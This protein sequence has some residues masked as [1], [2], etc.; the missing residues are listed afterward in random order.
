VGAKQYNCCIISAAEI[1]LRGWEGQMDK[2]LKKYFSEL[3]KKGNKARNEKLTP[4]ERTAI[5]K[6][7]V[8]ARIAKK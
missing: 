2:T 4:A 7:A 5:A 1:N 6:K 3:G 8:E